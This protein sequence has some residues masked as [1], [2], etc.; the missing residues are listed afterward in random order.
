MICSTIIVTE[1]PGIE[2][3]RNAEIQLS[4]PKN[5]DHTEILSDVDV[6]DEKFKLSTKTKLCLYMY[7]SLYICT[8]VYLTKPS[9]NFYLKYIS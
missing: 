4:C 2:E 3:L 5:G 6:A 8:L 9:T 7:V 1:G